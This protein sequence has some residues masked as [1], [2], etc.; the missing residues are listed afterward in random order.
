MKK[1]ADWRLGFPEH[2]DSRAPPG[3]KIIAYYVVLIAVLGWMKRKNLQSDKRKPRK[4]ERKQE[5][6]KAKSIGCVRRMIGGLSLFLL[7]VFLLFPEKTQGFCVT[8]LD[9]GQGDGI[10]FR[11]PDGTT[12]LADGGSSD[13]KQVGKYRIEPF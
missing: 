2:G 4:K 12:Y 6:F 9:V 8:F 11:G 3:W 7:A 5:D 1:A 10:F 13:V